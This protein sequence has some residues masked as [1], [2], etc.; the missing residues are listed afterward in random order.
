MMED[1]IKQIQ[2]LGWGYPI[3]QG[4]V[5]ML[6]EA[7]FAELDDMDPVEAKRRVRDAMG[8]AKATSDETDLIEECVDD[9]DNQDS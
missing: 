3:A 8:E 9:A 2:Q 5:P 6:P 1:R 4:I 7:L